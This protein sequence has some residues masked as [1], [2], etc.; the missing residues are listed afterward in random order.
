M[1]AWFKSEDANPV[2]RS[3]VG[4]VYGEVN[5]GSL[6]RKVEEGH[7]AKEPVAFLQGDAAAGFDFGRIMKPDFTICSVTRYTGGAMQRILQHHSPNFLHGHWGER[8]GVAYY[9][10]WVVDQDES[11]VT[12]WLV[13]CGNSAGVAYKGKERKNIGRN[14]VVKT[15]GDVHLYINNGFEEFSDFAVME[16]IV[17][18]RALSDDEMWST[19]VYLNSK[20]DHGSQ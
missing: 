15:G 20:L 18:S 4:N 5:K 2:W 8:V 14:G 1:V 13:M 6:S 11:S 10:G 7:G 12:D 16:L 19:M 3:A 9:G 17:W